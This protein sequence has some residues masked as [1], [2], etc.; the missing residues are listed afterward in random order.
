MKQLKS[1]Q[2]A[3]VT[4]AVLAIGT[5]SGCD[6]FNPTPTQ[7]ELPDS[8]FQAEN[9]QLMTTNG[10]DDFGGE[11]YTLCDGS[12]KFHNANRAYN[13]GKDLSDG[14]ISFMLNGSKDWQMWFLASSRDN[15]ADC[16]KLVYKD[17]LLFFTTSELSSLKPLA[18]ATAEEANYRENAWNKID[19]AFRTEGNVC[20]A[21][22]TV[23]DSAVC[24][25]S[26]DQLEQA[27]IKNGN[28]THTRSEEF[29]TGNY[30]CA[31]VWYGDCFLRLKPIGST[32]KTPTKIACL[33]DSITY[34]ANADNSYTD[35]YPAQLQKLLGA[36]YDV[37]NFG[38]SGATIRDEADDP[39]R[40]TSE[41]HGATLFCPDIAIIMLGTNDS[42][43]YQVPTV[44][45]V[46]NAYKTLISDLLKLNEETE[47]I[48][49]TSPYAYSSA[50]QIN[51]EN[52][53]KTIVPAQQAIADEY[54]LQ[55]VPMHEYTKNMNGNFADGIHPTSVGYT[56][57]AYRMYCDFTNEPVDEE[58]V[59]SFKDKK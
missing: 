33:G 59:S 28:F 1:W 32:G 18:S 14:S 7:E 22:L 26:T 52:I 13:Y 35:S 4:A 40:K 48:I 6:L 37:M 53:E 17:D 11:P 58:Y 29:E 15:N 9:W 38:K 30:I 10:K 21:T 20:T 39:Y 50:Y 19:L 45:S 5:L 3:V 51:N 43:T 24:F 54:G 23:N 25:T 31:K 16:Y 36:E 47:I 27:T 46:K 34:G 55:L 8:F 56:Y 57:I 12:I 41:Y 42:K 2:I 49:A 44:S